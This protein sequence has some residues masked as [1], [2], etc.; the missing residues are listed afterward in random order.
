MKL[1]IISDIHVDINKDKNYQFDFDDDFVITCGDISGDRFATEDWINANI[2]NGVFVEGNHLGYNRVTFDENDTKEHSIK[3]LKKKFK[4]GTVRF[5]E[6]DIYII[7]DIV[8][9]GCTL[10]SDFALYDNPVYCSRLASKSMNDFRYVKV[11]DKGSVRSLYTSDTVKWHKKSVKFINKTCKDYP[12]K[13]IVVVTHY[14]PSVDCVSEEYKG[15]MLNAAFA[16]DLEWLIEE[17]DNLVLWCHGH[18]HKDVDLIKYGTRVVCCPWGYFN[19]NN[20]DISTY[21]LIVDTDTL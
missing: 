16:S 11:K 1:R 6:N 4:T 19:E 8:F 14:A 18:M 2:R 21:G 9:A 3:Y 12:D 7:D 10:Y 20:K 13:K 5:L 17:N 15:D